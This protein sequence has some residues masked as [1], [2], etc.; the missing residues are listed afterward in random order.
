MKF[1]F[2]QHQILFVLPKGGKRDN[3]SAETVTHDSSDKPGEVTILY[4]GQ[5]ADNT[6]SQSQEYF[7]L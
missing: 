5:G 1:H 4:R 6:A 7:T 2:Q 3:K